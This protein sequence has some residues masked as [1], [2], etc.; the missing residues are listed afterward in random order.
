MTTSRRKR[1][2][3]MLAYKFDTYRLNTWPK[4]WYVQPKINGERCRLEITL[5]S[6]NLY[7]STGLPIK[8]VPHIEHLIRSLNIPPITLDGELYIHSYK[9]QQIHSIVSL[10]NSLHKDYKKIQ[11]R[12]FDVISEASQRERV[13]FLKEFFESFPPSDIIQLVPT[14]PSSSKMHLM[15]LF[16]YY[17]SQGYE[18]II[19]RHPDKPYIPKKTT[20]MMKLKDF[21]QET[22]KIVGYEQEIDIHGTPK[23]SLGAI[24]VKLSENKTNNVGTG[25][26]EDER[27]SLWIERDTLLGR[28]AKVQYQERSVDGHLLSSSF[29]GFVN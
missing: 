19:I 1:T 25:F 8:S 28:Y 2:G 26:T 29:K 12:C 24:V 20:F 23:D 13:E 7:S 4:P 10:K 5:D 15:T 17:T 21:K 27:I 16:D 14:H 6:I 11:F 22:F 18:G 3:V 9:Q